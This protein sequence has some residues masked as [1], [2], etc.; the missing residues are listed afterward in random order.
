MNT[1]TRTVKIK[2][3][4]SIIN[5]IKKQKNL[6]LDNI[7]EKKFWKKSRLVIHTEVK[8]LYIPI[9]IYEK[10][11]NSIAIINNL[12]DYAYFYQ[13]F[14]SLAES[15]QSEYDKKYFKTK[16]FNL[17]RET[18]LMII[19]DNEL[20]FYKLVYNNKT[21]DSYVKDFDSMKFLKENIKESEKLLL[22][23]Y[24]FTQFDYKDFFTYFISSRMENL[25][26][27][28]MITK[29][30]AHNSKQ[31]YYNIQD[32][33]DCVMKENKDEQVQNFI[34]A[35]EIYVT[36]ESLTIEIIHTKETKIELEVIRSIP[37]LKHS[38][39]NKL[40]PENFATSFI[41]TEKN[42]TDREVLVEEVSGSPPQPDEYAEAFKSNLFPKKYKQQ[43]Y[44][45]P[46]KLPVRKFGKQKCMI[47]ICII[48]LI[49][50]VWLSKICHFIETVVNQYSLSEKALNF[51]IGISHNTC[52]IIDD[53]FKSTNLK[54]KVF[55]PGRKDVRNYYYNSNHY[56][57]WYWGMMEK[58]LRKG[59]G[60]YYKK[61]GPFTWSY[62]GF[63][64]ENQMDGNGQLT[65]EYKNFKFLIEGI[66]NANLKMVIGILHSQI[67]PKVVNHKENTDFFYITRKF[68]EENV[69][70]L[71]D[72]YFDLNILLNIASIKAESQF[73]LKLARKSKRNN[74]KKSFRI[75]Q[76]KERSPLESKSERKK[77]GNTNNLFYKP[78]KIKGNSLKLEGKLGYVLL[79]IMFTNKYIFYNIYLTLNNY[80]FLL[81]CNF[82]LL[83]L[84]IVS[85]VES[86]LADQLIYVWSGSHCQKAIL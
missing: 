84:L 8:T 30:V 69:E 52:F 18:E 42:I 14:N 74:A 85:M 16:G 80:K 51:K 13:N 19:G 36:R 54:E 75:S 86:I 5:S 49:F 38:D 10:D 77:P 32:L 23:T 83:I 56:N 53:S 44:T 40:Q 9:L 43:K 62:Y 34:V 28:D 50:L 65:I 79:V 11:E 6:V 78:R 12:C 41:E 55:D 3:F 20:D 46:E 59:K 70:I 47:W 76:R 68:L 27:S 1:K 45:K 61:Q 48:G 82:F 24:Q 64:A 4:R 57:W 17:Y 66:W 2:N 21:K 22:L 37:E 60:V 29:N 39:S 73:E 81:I 35:D 67:I 33:K 63:W 15:K 58:G 71:D 7:K 72:W 26:K 25:A 31:R